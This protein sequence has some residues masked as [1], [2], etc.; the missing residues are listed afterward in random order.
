[1]SSSEIPDSG[2]AHRALQ[3]V[4]DAKL[5][6]QSFW[7]SLNSHSLIP[8]VCYQIEHQVV[9]QSMYK[10]MGK[11]RRV[12]TLEQFYEI[13]RLAAVSTTSKDGYML[14]LLARTKVEYSMEGQEKGGKKS[15]NP[16]E[17][18]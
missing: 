18:G 5:E 8:Y 10:M 17:G 14:N 4:H 16:F 3:L 11:M 13:T 2:A 12:K 7:R 15:I 9:T 6:R 1:M